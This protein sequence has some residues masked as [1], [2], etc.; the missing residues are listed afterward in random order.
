MADQ[1][2]APKQKPDEQWLLLK[3]TFRSQWSGLKLI[4]H[5][6]RHETG[7]IRELLL[8][9]PFLI[10]ALFFIYTNRITYF[11]HNFGNY[12]FEEHFLSG[13]QP[14]IRALL[15]GRFDRLTL[16][17]EGPVYPLVVALTG[18]FNGPDILKNALLVNTLCGTGALLAAYYLLRRLFG[19]A[20][21]VV[22]LIL[23][24]TNTVYFEYT[25]TACL[26]PL[27][28]LL[29]LLSLLGLFTYADKTGAQRIGRLI[30]SALFA[31]LSA[32]TLLHGA[33]LLPFFWISLFVLKTE[34]EKQPLF[35]GLIFSGVFL[36]TFLFF[37]FLVRKA[38]SPLFSTL[39]L[40]DLGGNNPF[41]THLKGLYYRLLMD[42]DILLGWG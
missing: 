28:L 38:G 17:L 24:S 36:I 31:A 41:F 15:A 2:K 16:G 37:V 11:Y 19:T 7:L 13:I 32:M 42:I 21:A 39:P 12:G 25:Y 9:L 20:T 10:T 1:K 40:I 14:V 35:S 23:V 22:S 3:K 33:L 8:F 29:T 5:E 26:A 34:K 6:L 27:F 30:G 18:L 4:Y